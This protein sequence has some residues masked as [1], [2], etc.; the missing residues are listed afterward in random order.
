M[1]SG[2]L[3]H[4]EKTSSLSFIFF[5]VRLLILIG[6]AL[7]FKVNVEQVSPL[8]TRG[9]SSTGQWSVPSLFSSRRKA[10]GLCVCP[11]GLYR[12]W[13]TVFSIR[14]IFEAD[15]VSAPV[16]SVNPVMRT[17]HSVSTAGWVIFILAAEPLL[18]GYSPTYDN[19]STIVSRLVPIVSDGRNN[20]RTFLC[21]IQ[22]PLPSLQVWRAI[23]F[24]RINPL[25]CFPKTKSVSLVKFPATVYW[26]LLDELICRSSMWYLR[27]VA[28][29]CE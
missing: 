9:V 26:S 21:S 28:S 7:T 19:G 4:L 8:A 5:C 27:K 14:S 23:C 10:Y 18:Q 2:A 11:C 1:C 13:V 24:M 6:S 15:W 17:I 22:Q 3:N 16:D 25:S 29:L 12:K 20:S